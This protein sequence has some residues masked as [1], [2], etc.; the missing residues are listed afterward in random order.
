MAHI[1]TATNFGKRLV[2][3]IASPDRLSRFRWS[4]NFGG[5]PIFTP[6]D[7]ARL[8]CHIAPPPYPLTVAKEGPADQKLKR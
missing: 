5:L 7:L 3:I 4:V 8:S 1:I 6:R 2:A